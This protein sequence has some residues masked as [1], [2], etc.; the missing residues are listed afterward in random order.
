MIFYLVAYRIF[1]TEDYHVEVFGSSSDVEKFV[2]NHDVIVLCVDTLKLDISIGKE[3][4]DSED[5]T[6]DETF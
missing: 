6:K 5:S 3:V 4:A 1:K 2:L